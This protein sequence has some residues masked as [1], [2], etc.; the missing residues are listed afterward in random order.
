MSCEPC[1]GARFAHLGNLVAPSTLHQGSVNKVPCAM[2]VRALSELSRPRRCS[3]CTD[4]FNQ[5]DL[6]MNQVIWLVGAVVI[7]LAILGFFGLR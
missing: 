3:Y 4:V 5:E 2:N 6:G 1:S 7:V